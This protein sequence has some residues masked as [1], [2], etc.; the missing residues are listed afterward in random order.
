MKGVKGVKRRPRPDAARLARRLRAGHPLY[1]KVA[2][3]AT[4]LDLP[5]P[6]VR[7]PVLR[8]HEA[9]RRLAEA[10]LPGLAS[11]CDRDRAP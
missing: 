6:W 3:L 8:R 1:C 4:G 5:P 7:R 2:A 10:S 9:P 11:L